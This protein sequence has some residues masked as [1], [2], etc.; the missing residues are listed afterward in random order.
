ME[1][2]IAI[3][4]DDEE[5]CLLYKGEKWFVNWYIQLNIFIYVASQNKIYY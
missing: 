2:F 5:K 1:Y 3:E 4:N